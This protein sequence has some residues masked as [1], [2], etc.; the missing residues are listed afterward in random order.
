M[1]M[2]IFRPLREGQMLKEVRKGTKEILQAKCIASLHVSLWH[3]IHGFSAC[4][5]HLPVCYSTYSLKFLWCALYL[6]E[7]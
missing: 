2:Q 6:K 3:F 7:N 4:S 5:G 1:K